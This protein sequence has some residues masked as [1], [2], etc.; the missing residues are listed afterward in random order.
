MPLE[1]WL[2][3]Y[4]EIQLATKLW[5][6]LSTLKKIFLVE[7]H[8]YSKNRRKLTEDEKK[9]WGIPT[10]DGLFDKRNKFAKKSGEYIANKYW[11]DYWFNFDANRN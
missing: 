1:V 3:I 9:F 10:Y 8:E 5:I 7:A 4:G 11:K 2:W 6:P